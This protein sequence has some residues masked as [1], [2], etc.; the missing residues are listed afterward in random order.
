MT[1]YERQYRRKIM[2]QLA[3]VFVQ[4]ALIAA[5]W[6]FYLHRYFSERISPAASFTIA[7]VIALI[8]IVKNRLWR[9]FTDRSFKG[10]VKSVKFKES[11]TFSKEDMRASATRPLYT[12]YL[13]IALDGGSGDKQKKMTIESFEPFYQDMWYHAGDRIVYHRGTKFPLITCGRRFC[14]YCGYDLTDGETSCRV[15][16]CENEPPEC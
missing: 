3:A 5:L 6:I 4:I 12:L 8:P 10:I 16:G 9:L 15:C 13:T 14:A 7:Y 2:K 1:V 11:Q